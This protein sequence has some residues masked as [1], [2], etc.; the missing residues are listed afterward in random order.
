MKYTLNL[1]QL[2]V[3]CTLAELSKI[4]KMCVVHRRWV[5]PFISPHHLPTLLELDPLFVTTFLWIPC[6]VWR[7]VHDGLSAF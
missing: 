4:Q 6:E 2:L 7:S 5:Y 1:S 3:S